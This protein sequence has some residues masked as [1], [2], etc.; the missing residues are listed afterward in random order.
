MLLFFVYVFVREFYRNYISILFYLCY[1]SYNL[2]DYFYRDLYGFIIFPSLYILFLVCI[3]CERNRTPF[4]Y[5][6]SEREFVSGFNVEYSRIFFT[7]LFA[8]EYII[9][10]IFSWLGSIRMF[11][12]CETGLLRVLRHDHQFIACFQKADAGN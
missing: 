3:L 6:E 5:A 7:C 8:C 1:G 11:G 10:F 2:C 4:D 12:I 9:I